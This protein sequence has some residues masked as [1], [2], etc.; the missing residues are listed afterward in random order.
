[1]QAR[2]DSTARAPGLLTALRCANLP[3]ALPF[4]EAAS[5]A[6]PRPRILTESTFMSAWTDLGDGVFV[7]QSRCCQMNSTVVIHD[8]NAIVLDP[9]V[10]PSELSDIAAFVERQAPRFENT[11]LVFTHPHWDHVL[12]KPW[13]PAAATVA[14]VGFGDELERDATEI[15]ASTKKWVESEGEA[16]P[17][18]FEA[19]T[20]ALTLR[21]TIGVKI[22]G[23]EMLVYDVP[24]H[25]PSQIACYFPEIGLFVAGDT[26]SDIEVPWL[27]GPPWVYRRSLQALHWVFEQEQVRHLVPGHG[28]VARG[29]TDAY[30]RLLRDIDYLLHL[31]GEVGNAFTLG[32]SLEET[33]DRLA[34]MSYVGKDA[35]YSMNDVHRA[36]V[37]FAFD[38][39]REQAEMRQESRS[40]E[41]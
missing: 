2:R 11:T 34:K 6:A 18:P 19:F 28:S 38:G 36:N 21:G 37:K 12:G 15:E 7:R 35:A 23:R 8:G 40:K 24:G 30:K 1:M 32:A 17:R 33:Q 29:R 25:S 4:A 26:L 10:L 22:G 20:P 14:H 5:P 39:L 13:F 16:W 3:L 31:E 27:D 41:T 9:G